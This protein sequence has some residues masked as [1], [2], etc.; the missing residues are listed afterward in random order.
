MFGLHYLLADIGLGL[1]ALAAASGFVLLLAR[2]VPFISRRYRAL[3]WLH[4]LSG[5]AAFL[6]YLLT[7]LLAPRF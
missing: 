2:K 3:R 4:L 1:M 7:Y 5:G 6:V